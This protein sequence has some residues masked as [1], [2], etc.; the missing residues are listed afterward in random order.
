MDNTLKLYVSVPSIGWVELT[1]LNG[2]FLLS[3]RKPKP[4]HQPKYR[5]GNHPPIKRKP[6]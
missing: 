2:N 4:A 1:P 6:A 5:P 3:P